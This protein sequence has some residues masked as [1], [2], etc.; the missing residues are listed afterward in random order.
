MSLQQPITPTTP[1][2]VVEAAVKSLKKRKSTGVGNIPA[3]I[4][5]Q[6]GET[7]AKALLI[8]CNNIWRTRERPTPW[9]QSLVIALPKNGY[10][11]LY[12]NYRTISLIGNPSKVMLKIILN[13]LKPEEEKIIAEEQ[14]GFRPGPAPQS[15]SSTSGYFVRS[16]SSTKRASIMSSLT[17]KR[18]ST[19]C[20]TRHFGQL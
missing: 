18:H 2:S 11:Q 20:G 4:L 3:E 1:F 9:T 5:Q 14:A 13:C 15:R 7:M 17:S 10:S 6:G 8:I 12:Q 19:G 16:T